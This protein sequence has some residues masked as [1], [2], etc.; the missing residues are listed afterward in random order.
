[1]VDGD[2]RHGNEACFQNCVVFLLERLQISEPFGGHL[3][4]SVQEQAETPNARTEP[5]G[6]IGTPA[7]TVTDT[8]P[9]K[10]IRRL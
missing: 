3:A 2:V 5:A 8:T 6:A 7:R 10:K 1:M 4:L 9:T